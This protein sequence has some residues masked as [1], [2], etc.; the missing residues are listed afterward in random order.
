MQALRGE[1]KQEVWAKIIF[2]QQK[3]TTFKQKENN[4]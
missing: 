2:K 1:R 3:F 4:K